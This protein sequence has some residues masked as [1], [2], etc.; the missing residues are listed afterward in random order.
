[1]PF[2]TGGGQGHGA[3]VLLCHVWANSNRHRWIRE[4]RQTPGLMGIRVQLLQYKFWSQCFAEYRVLIDVVGAAHRGLCF[5]AGRREVGWGSFCKGLLSHGGRLQ[6]K[7]QP[8]M[9]KLLS[10]PPAQPFAVV[11]GSSALLLSWAPA[12]GCGTPL[13]LP[14]SSPKGLWAQRCCGL[15][16]WDKIQQN[17]VRLQDL[18]EGSRLTC[19]CCSVL[20]TNNFWDYLRCLP[21]K[22]YV[23]MVSAYC[24]LWEHSF[25]KRALLLWLLSTKVLKCSHGWK[26]YFYPVVKLGFGNIHMSIIRGL[27]TWGKYW[28]MLEVKS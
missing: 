4:R 22:L 11:H 25:K 12:G 21:L 26:T 1:M 6:H 16:V 15:D 5:R 23:A 24:P 10:L 19:V 18:G 13:A 2:L 27:I 28:L 20:K 14:F 3:A 7:G 9:Q 8:L 17:C